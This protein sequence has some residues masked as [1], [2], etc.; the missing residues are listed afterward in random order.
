MPQRP[1]TADS[2]AR[3]IKEKNEQN[4]RI[5]YRVLS[6]TL[7]KD[8]ESKPYLLIMTPSVLNGQTIR[9]IVG[10]A[11]PIRVILSLRNAAQ[12]YYDSQE[13]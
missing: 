3:E 13:G 4:W 9:Q 12:G 1:I 2:Q 8:H 5:K 7:D 10:D 6:V 11:N